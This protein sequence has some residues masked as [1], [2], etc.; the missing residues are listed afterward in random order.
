MSINNITSK[1]MYIEHI[2]HLVLALQEAEEFSW[3]PTLMNNIHT[4]N[5]SHTNK[6]I[7]TYKFTTHRQAHILHTTI[8]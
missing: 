8:V 1:D 2:F 3:L 4:H 7:S 6:G 5:T